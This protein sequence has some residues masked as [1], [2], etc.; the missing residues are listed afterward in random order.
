MER[1]GRYAEVDSGSMIIK[2]NLSKVPQNLSLLAAEMSEELDAEY[3]VIIAVDT[4]Y[5]V[6]DQYYYGRLDYLNQRNMYFYG[7]V[8]TAAGLI[9]MAITIIMLGY[10]AGVPFKNAKTRKAERSEER[11]VGKE[12]RSRWSPYH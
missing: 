2:N 5:Q 6:K 12:C 9:F 1:L 10:L 8:L 4:G 7:M 11:R 3:K